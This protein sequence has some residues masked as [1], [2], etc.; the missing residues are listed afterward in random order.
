MSQR[1]QLPPVAW[2][3]ERVEERAW[4]PSVERL[5]SVLDLRRLISKQGHSGGELQRLGLGWAIASGAPLLFL[6]EPLAFV[7]QS[8]RAD[9]MHALLDACV[10]S[11]QWWMMA[12]HELPPEDVLARMAVWTLDT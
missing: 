12:S 2:L 7:A 10:E 11:G 3:A 5:F 6:D 1:L 4:G 9:L 8:L